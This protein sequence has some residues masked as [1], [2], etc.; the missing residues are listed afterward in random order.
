MSADGPYI[1]S[2]LDEVARVDGRL[3]SSQIMKTRSEK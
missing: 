1:A 3:P 2:G